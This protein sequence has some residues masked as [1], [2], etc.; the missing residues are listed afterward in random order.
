MNQKQLEKEWNSLLYSEKM[1]LKKAFPVREAGWQKKVEKY[2]PDKL[3]H[4]L[5]V[6]FYKAF[7]MI[8]EKGAIFIEKTYDREKKEQN[9]KVDEYAANLKNNAKSVKIFGRKAAGSKA[10]NTAISAVEGIGMGILGMGI[11]DIPLFL[12]VILKSIYELALTYGFA[13][14]T[15]EEQLFIL[16]L[17]ET[18]MFH[19]EE[20]LQENE[21]IDEWILSGSEFS[22]E[23]KEQM[24]S[25]SQ[26]L[27]KELLYLKFVQGVPIVGF[28]GGVSDVIYQKKIADYAAL[29]YKKRFLDKNGGSNGKR[30]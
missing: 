26:V 20:L 19:G 1:F 2:V 15:E 6:T 3:E 10:V 5:N 17:I 18:A 25:T 11:P 23:K 28:L 4:T 7:E 29:K 13:Y 9:Y 16:K 22:K 21:A 14:D 8:F 12:S 24:Q 30:S 27:S